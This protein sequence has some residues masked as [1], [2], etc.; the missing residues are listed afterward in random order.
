MSFSIPFAA[1]ATNLAYQYDPAGTLK[2]TVGGS[3]SGD[4]DPIGELLPFAGASG[5]NLSNT[6]T[7]RPTARAS[8][9]V[10]NGRP[11]FDFDGDD[12][13]SGALGGAVLASLNTFTLYMVIATTMTVVGAGSAGSIGIAESNTGV[14][15]RF[16]YPRINS[17]TMG[18]VGL[19]HQTDTGSAANFNTAASVSVND[20]AL[21]IIAYE[22]AAAGSYTIYKDGTSIATNANA[23]GTAVTINIMAMGVNYRTTITNFYLGQ[24]GVCLGYST[25][26]IA[27]TFGGRTITQMLNDYYRRT[28]RR[29]RRAA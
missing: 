12:Y 7:A 17:A 20:G 19:N 24:M 8:I 9:A 13:L 15:N 2:Q 1:P 21:H 3:A 26:N 5:V 27:T 6:L 4:G 10:F 25:N 29:R 11:A 28:T 23:P 18:N 22:R 16:L 14:T